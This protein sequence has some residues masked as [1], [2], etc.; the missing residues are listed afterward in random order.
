MADTTVVNVKHPLRSK[1]LWLLV[2]V[3]LMI[4]LSQ[5]LDT[6]KTVMSPEVYKQIA[7]WL[8]VILSGARMFSN[9]ALSFNAPLFPPTVQ[10]DINQTK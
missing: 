4:Q 6:L 3:E 2:L 10:Q 5:N 1:T 7:I 8:P 9:T